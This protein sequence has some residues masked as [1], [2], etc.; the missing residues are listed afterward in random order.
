MHEHYSEEFARLAMQLFEQD[1]QTETVDVVVQ[2]A[3]RAVA[4]DAASV[5]LIHAR[6][7]GVEPVGATNEIASRADQLQIAT[8]QGP[9]LDAAD[10]GDSFLVRDT[11]TDQRWP[12]WCRAIR[13]DLGIRSVL[14]VRIS[15]VTEKIGALNL[16]AWRPDGSTPTTT[17]SRTC[18]HGTPRS[19]WPPTAPPPTSGTRS[20]PAS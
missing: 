1:G 17:R 13:A 15:T 3:L 20:T 10:E 18:W 2:F 9:C 4:A 5:L 19:P 8:G 7:G 16:Y 12:T 11:E 14:S 6:S